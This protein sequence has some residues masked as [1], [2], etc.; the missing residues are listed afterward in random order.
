MS[1]R[2]LHVVEDFSSGNTGVTAVVR[3]IVEWQARHCEWVGVYATGPVDLPSPHGVF[4]EAPELGTTGRSW[5]YPAGGLASLD[6]VIDA[7]GVTVIHLHGLWRAA[8]L[9]GLKA[10][11]TRGLPTVLSVHG[12]TSPWALGGQGLLK[13]LK[14]QIYWAFVRSRFHAVDALHAI[15][16]LEAEHMA[17]FFK[18]ADSVVIPN[19]IAPD[20]LE[21]ELPSDQLPP[22]PTFVFL[23]RLHPVKAVDILIEAFSSAK[24]QHDDWRLVLAG[25]PEVPEYVEYLQ[26]LAAR[27]PRSARIEF[28]GPVFKH[29]KTK[30]L[31]DAW[32]LVAPSHTEVIGMVNLEAAAMST[33]SVTTHQT[34]LTDWCEGGGVLVGPGVES[35]RAAL[36]EVSSWTMEE[37]LIR[38]NRSKKLVRER[39]SQAVVGPAWIELYGKISAQM[40][41]GIKAHK[42]WPKPRPEV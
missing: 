23:G 38:G 29:E 1:I 14:K 8:T 5:R 7:H 22:T 27:S 35:L 15:T 28:I 24:F 42:R 9:L 6:R 26:K 30:L 40:T 18:R 3:Q 19:A 12:Q 25:P 32:V 10:A 34:G 11:V 4:V 13:R 39:Y 20:P 37:R 16:P 31:R 41:D 33:P 2:I 17:R 36:E 21:A